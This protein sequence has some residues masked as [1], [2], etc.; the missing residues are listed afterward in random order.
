LA[1]FEVTTEAHPSLDSWGPLTIHAVPRD[2]YT[3]SSN[4]PVF[5]SDKKL[6]GILGNP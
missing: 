5:G 1:G 6:D 2:L 4:T 3:P